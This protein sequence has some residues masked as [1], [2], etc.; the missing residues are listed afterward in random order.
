MSLARSAAASLDDD[1]SVSANSR[2]SGGGAQATIEVFNAYPADGSRPQHVVFH[3]TVNPKAALRHLRSHW[4]TLSNTAAEGRSWFLLW[5][6]ALCIK[7]VDLGK[8]PRQVVT[9]RQPDL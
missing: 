8:R 7:Q 9:M 5:A 1:T 4:A 6:G 3:A 2:T